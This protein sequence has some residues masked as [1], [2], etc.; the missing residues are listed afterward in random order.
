MGLKYSICIPNYNSERFIGQTIES[1]LS[2]TVPRERYEVIVSDNASSDGSLQ[3]IRR[4][5]PGIRV[6]K[7]AAAIPAIENWNACVKEA[8]GEY[9]ILLHSDDLIDR[10]FLEVCGAVLD[11]YPNI[12]MVSCRARVIDASGRLLQE[13]R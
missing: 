2:Q 12:E 8:K 1:A 13:Q 5:L 9:V 11:R 3:V 7:R 4:Y 10:E 6:I